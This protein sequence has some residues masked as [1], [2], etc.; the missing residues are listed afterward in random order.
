MQPLSDEERQ[1]RRDG[2]GIYRY[3]PTSPTKDKPY[4]NDQ[5]AF[6]QS[7]AKIRIIIGPNRAGK[8]TPAVAELAAH[9]LGEDYPDWF[10]ASNVTPKPP[11]TVWMSSPKFPES[12]VDDARLKR[13]FRGYYFVDPETRD[14]T[15]MPPLI[16]PSFL[17]NP[18]CLDLKNNK[19]FETKNDFAVVLKSANQKTTASAGEEPELIFVDEMTDTDIWS[20]YLGRVSTSRYC[21]I[22]HVLTD[23]G[24]GTQ[25]DYLDWL[26]GKGEELGLVEFFRFSHEN[27]HID[28]SHHDETLS[29]LSP[30]QYR[31][32]RQGQTAGEVA[33]CYPFANRWHQ[34][35]DPLKP[36]VPNPYG[37]HGNW[38]PKN[39]CFEI[40]KHWTRYVVHD[41]GITNPGA[42]AWIA[43]EPGVEN[44]YV[45]RGL[46]WREPHSAFIETVR[47]IFEAT[48][49]ERIRVFFV[50]PKAIKQRMQFGFSA[51]KE[52][53]K[54]ALYN[55]VSSKLLG[56]PFR[57]ALAP[58]SIEA[59]IRP[60]RIAYLTAMLDP[61][62]TAVPMMWFFDDGSEGME[63]LKNEFD[64]YH[65][66]ATP[67][68]RADNPDRPVKKHDHFI[69]AL[70]V[71]A[72]MGFR[73]FADEGDDHSVVPI[74]RD[75][76]DPTGKI[77]EFMESDKYEDFGKTA[78]M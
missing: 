49:G 51:P 17:K 18:S 23:S 21:R 46:Y 68:G 77:R 73:W 64:K 63:A 7:Q 65:W 69:W 28:D 38:I 25:T 67:K 14:R 24:D 60:T 11:M 74:R 39:Q 30:T 36:E 29:L 57:W 15:W 8:T 50:D 33:R 76:G 10:R 1:A 12:I 6:H 70:E 55:A 37:W 61:G 20:E 47:D 54:I 22:I 78:F 52:R 48:G 53:T 16:P 43:V 71:C 62:N 72:A 13:L 66:A 9:C 42:C 3:V 75:P 34:D 59:M 40:P 56:R 45:Y 35:Y 26:K 32:R 27:P 2:W 5:R 19:V 31:I 4:I 58:P 41:P 44:C